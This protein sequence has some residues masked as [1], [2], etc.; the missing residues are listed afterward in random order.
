MCTK[1]GRNG[2]KHLLRDSVTGK[3]LIFYSDSDIFAITSKDTSQ[4]QKKR[5]MRRLG[6]VLPL[7]LFLLLCVSTRSFL[8][9][10]QV[11]EDVVS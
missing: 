4:L 3:R 9:K 5:V 11:S 1:V 6:M 8:N 10:Q 7:L 2:F